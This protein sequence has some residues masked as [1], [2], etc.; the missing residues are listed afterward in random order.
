MARDAMG[1]LA[2]A[3]QLN[4]TAT[5]IKKRDPVNALKLDSLAS[6]KRASA[7]RQMTRRPKRRR[8]RIGTVL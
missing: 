7:I 1:K 8:S 2:E 4:K 5:K 6:K 3:D